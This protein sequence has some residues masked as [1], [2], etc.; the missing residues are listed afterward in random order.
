MEKNEATHT[1]RKSLMMWPTLAFIS[2][3]VLCTVM[4]NFHDR[5]TAL[6]EAEE[7][8]KSLL[9]MNQS[10]FVFFRDEVRA[11]ILDKY[12]DMSPDFFEPALM[13][14][15]FAIRR[16]N[17]IYNT[18][19]LPAY[20]YKVCALNA[21]SPEDEADPYEAEVILRF[22][23]HQELRDHKAIRDIGGEPYCVIMYPGTKTSDPCMRCHSDPQRAP[24]EL[25]ARYGDQRGFGWPTGEIVSA[26]SIQIPLSERFHEANMV[27]AK[28]SAGFAAIFLVLYGLMGFLVKRLIL[29]PLDIIRSK[30]LQIS[31]DSHEHLGEEIPLPGGSELRD[32]TSALN[33]MS[34]GLRSERDLLEHHVKL[35]TEDLRR[36][37]E[38]LQAEMGER[39]EVEKAVR[40]REERLR[41]FIEHAPVPLAMFDREMRYVSYSKR[42]LRDYNLE[43]RDLKGLS[44]Y[45]IFPNLPERWKEAH[46]RA[47][48]GEVV[49]AE[50]DKFM[51]KDG[52][53]LW[54]CWEVRPWYDQTDNVAGIV[55]FHEDISRHKQAEESL[56]ISLEE[57]VALLKE[58]H[59]RVKNNLQII[60][61]LL[62]LEANRLKSDDAVKALQDT[63]S[64]VR[65][66]AL[67]HETLYRSKNMARIDLASYL[68]D[69][70]VKIIASFELVSGYVHLESRVAPVTLPLEKAVP[71]S[72]IANEILSNALKHAFPRQRPGK[73]TVELQ[74]SG[75]DGELW[76]LRFS[77]DGVGLPSEPDH[78]PKDTL[79][80]QLIHDL[81]EQLD[82]TLTIQSSPG[83]GTCFTLLFPMR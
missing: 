51:R 33:T 8:A 64:R 82:G 66:M 78:E 49:R 75:T 48:A 61:S 28:L 40:E 5:R 10:L 65:S 35:R 19:E 69:L 67:L 26:Y 38:R 81:A 22:N 53:V 55:L 6:K 1:L 16:V 7:E 23:E 83:E 27:S 29:D 73:I 63:R 30:A 79:G 18:Q 2:A 57:K 50:E 46:R 59:H 39:M 25:L 52:S 12:Q 72:L 43:N 44:H 45:E 9:G 36:T 15:F 68:G 42:W 32:L 4:I 56:S 31:T 60:A 21:R 76:A 20:R 14:T 77:D 34:R 54:A 37:A 24:G 17:A 3:A 74:P 62:G 80:M 13:S 71:I 70:C 47:L 58:V 41:L 11:K